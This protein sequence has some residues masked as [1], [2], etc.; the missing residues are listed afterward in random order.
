MRL[1]NARTLKLEHFEGDQI[2]R[3][4]ILSHRW[5]DEEVTFDDIHNCPSHLKG[6]T[7]VTS[8]CKETL[9]YSAGLADVKPNDAASINHV[10]IDTCCIDK[11]SSAELSEAIN[12][13][14]GW[15]Q[16]AAVCFAYLS[17][18]KD[19]SEVA[20]SLWFSRGWTLQEL[21]APRHVR[22]YSSDWTQIGRKEDLVDSI[23]ST[24]QIPPKALS[25][26]NPDDF[27]VTERMSWAAKRQTRRIEDRAYS[28]I[29]IFG[30]NMP[31]LYGEG[32]RAFKRLQE[33]IIKSSN[34][35]SILLWDTGSAG[36]LEIL[37]S[38]PAEFRPTDAAPFLNSFTLSNAGLSL[39]TYISPHGWNIWLLY[40]REWRVM[41]EDVYN[42]PAPWQCA[43]H[44][45]IPVIFLQHLGFNRY[46]RVRFDSKSWS[47]V[48]DLKPGFPDVFP[49]DFWPSPFKALTISKSISDSSSVPLDTRYTLHTTLKSV[50][51]Y[52]PKRVSAGSSTPRKNRTV[53]YRF[54][55]T[56]IYHFA[57]HK[58]DAGS[59][60][61]P[62]D[63]GIISCLRVDQH[64]DII[65][66]FDRW[67]APVCALQYRDGPRQ[68]FRKSVR[69]VLE[70]LC[71]EAEKLDPKYKGVVQISTADGGFQLYR[72][73]MWYQRDETTTFSFVTPD[74][75]V[76]V[77]GSSDGYE[78]TIKQ[79]EAFDVPSRS[80]SAEVVTGNIDRRD[81]VCRAFNVFKRTSRGAILL[82]T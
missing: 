66:G 17:D 34:D 68:V 35:M 4:A 47:R 44:G 30:I 60:N 5:E 59:S 70:E 1:L 80:N 13:M 18:V 67:S 16:R 25:D 51:L 56:E 11:K 64:T 77:H 27:S 36:S 63:C 10:W 41:E 43:S 28:L 49:L 29:G 7:K 45:D 31:M 33:E 19:V 61:E 40:I 2:P 74:I 20:G 73:A 57:M 58:V 52:I 22:F 71:D 55:Q 32:A 37:A 42:H 69:K 48:S 3:Y 54:K 50:D 6:W 81:K 24:T 12:S 79:S 26:F 14:Y 82:T 78:V 53:D 76:E 38:S 9:K 62:V 23:A 46:R 39:S 15:Y 75:K 8:C 21:L 65:L 72:G